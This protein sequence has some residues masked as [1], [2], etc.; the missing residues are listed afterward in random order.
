LSAATFSSAGT[1]LPAIASS[2][3]ID[4]LPKRLQKK[5]PVR[6]VH[7]LAAVLIFFLILWIHSMKTTSIIDLVLRCSGYTYGP[8]IA[9]YGLGIFTRF[10]LK[11]QWVPLWCILAIGFTAFLDFNSESLLGGYRVGVELIAINAL[12][13]LIF[14]IS[15]GRERQPIGAG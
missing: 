15:F 8:L 9:L 5:I 11:H 14:S 6:L 2:I 12:F 7:A 10:K 1:I 3:E 4:L 13:F